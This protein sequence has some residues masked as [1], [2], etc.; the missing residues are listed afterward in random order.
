MNNS[1]CNFVG[2]NMDEVFEINWYCYA[3]L[4]Y[5]LVH[6]SITAYIQTMSTNIIHLLLMFS[7]CYTRRIKN[8]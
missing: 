4:K 5:K 7:T 8:V 1:N 2:V 3:V 6:I